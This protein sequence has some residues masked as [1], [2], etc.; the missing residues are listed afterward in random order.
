MHPTHTHIHTTFFKAKFALRNHDKILFLILLSN[1][2]CH[3]PI[4]RQLNCLASLNDREIDSSK[5]SAHNTLQEFKSIDF[6][7]ILPFYWSEVSTKD[8]MTPWKHSKRLI[9]VR[10]EIKPG[11]STHVPQK[12]VCSFNVTLVESVIYSEIT[13]C[14]E[15]IRCWMKWEHAHIISSPLHIAA[16]PWVQLG[17]TRVKI[18]P[19][20]LT[21]EVNLR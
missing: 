1:K 18:I 11:I 7:Q 9:K 6:Q 4:P 2:L 15:S 14:H 5:S 21:V 16:N 13:F 12:T 19:T 17:I 3:N 8:W 20:F 10:G